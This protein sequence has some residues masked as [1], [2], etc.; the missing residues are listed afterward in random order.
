MKTILLI[1]VVSLLL[2]VPASGQRL[3]ITTAVTASGQLGGE[4]GVKFRSE[5]FT[6][7]AGVSYM[8]QKVGEGTSQTTFGLV[9]GEVYELCRPCFLNIEKTQ[10]STHIGGFFLLNTSS[11]PTGKSLTTFG[12]VFGGG[13]ESFFI[14]KKFSVA[15]FLGLE[16]T[17]T[18][19]EPSTTTAYGTYSKVSLTWYF[20]I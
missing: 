19:T 14:Q 17:S 3:G 4:L 20:L 10:L 7:V 18:N 15:A 12:V 13:G 8:T 2:C 16:Y 11:P 5:C 6:G 1:A 9:V